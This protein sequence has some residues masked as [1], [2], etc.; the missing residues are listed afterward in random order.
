MHNKHSHSDLEAKLRKLGDNLVIEAGVKEDLKSHILGKVITTDRLPKKKPSSK[1]LLNWAPGFAMLLIV[2]SSGTAVLA[3]SAKPGQPLYAVDLFAETLQQ[4]LVRDEI[5]KA[6]LYAAISEERVAERDEIEAIDPAT[7]DENKRIRWEYSRTMAIQGAANSLERLKQVQ[8]VVLER[9]EQAENPQQKDAY[10]KLSKS[11]QQVI[12]RKA[13]R[14]QTL[15]EILKETADANKDEDDLSY[16]LEESERAKIRAQIR[17][18]FRADNP[19]RGNNK[20]NDIVLPDPKIPEDAQK[21]PRDTNENGVPDQ[22]EPE[23]QRTME[24]EVE[25][26]LVE[27]HNGQEY[28]NNS[29]I[30]SGINQILKGL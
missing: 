20:P 18:E 8:E 27:R 28:G 29:L 30:E 2:A 11:L 16:D 13:K 3:D 1:W 24:A 19:K 21:Q 23:Y 7:L 9:Y 15:E 12:D 10:L 4:R 17:K 26:D 14:A 5:A 25:G 22:D 6:K